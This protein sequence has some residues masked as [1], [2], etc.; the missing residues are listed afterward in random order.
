ME[1]G[2]IEG[3]V[4]RIVAPVL[5]RWPWIEYVAPIIGILGL[6]C[7]GALV[8]IY[9]ERKVS[10]HIQ[11]RLGPMHH[12]PHG[13]IQTVADALKLLHKE[14]LIPDRADRALMIIA[15]FIVF[16]PASLVYVVIP[17][18]PSW[19]IRDLNIG[20]LY[21]SA[22][23]ASTTLGILAGGW[24]G[25]N[26]WSLL[27]G[28][29]ASAQVISYEIPM[30]LSILVVVMLAGS[31][32]MVRIVE[33]Q[34]PV[35]FVLYPCGVIAFLTY[36]TSALAEVSRNPFDLPEAESELVAGY[37]TEYTGFRFA[38]FFLSEFSNM[39][40]ISMIAA[41]LFFGGWLGPLGLGP[42]VLW[43]AAKV[44]FFIFLFMWIK[45]TLPRLRI[46]QLLKVAW[47]GL[48]PIC[49]ANLGF[50]I[51]VLLLRAYALAA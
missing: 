25:N 41:T 50:A 45:W 36:L 18:A 51:V 33:E 48:I 26:K 35:P 37:H 16:V 43:F 12:G 6:M 32:S 8:L 28:L 22:V 4:N 9:L 42:S 3:F 10:G 47:L 1:P 20:V 40:A 27:G 34:S 24:S 15:P 14:D 17:F 46:D 39:M 49:L 29:R 30:V 44:A 38:I 23:M 11:S 21:I 13:I 2:R 7:V 5:G 31:M 19:I